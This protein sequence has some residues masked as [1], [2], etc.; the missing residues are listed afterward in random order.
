MGIIDVSVSCLY[1]S[2]LEVFGSETY[3]EQVL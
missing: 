2:S 3:V 1:T